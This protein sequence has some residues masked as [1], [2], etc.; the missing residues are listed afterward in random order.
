MSILPMVTMADDS[1]SCGD[2]LIWTYTESTGLLTITGSGEM[3]D[4]DSFP[5]YITSPWFHYSDNINTIVLD[6]GVESTGQFSF[7]SCSKCELIVLPQTIKHIGAY[8]FLGCHCLESIT[9]PDN[10]LSIGDHAF[11]GCLSLASISI[12]QNV[13]S[14]GTM[15]L[16]IA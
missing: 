1:G 15:V 10:V 9:I 3:Y 16:L 11:S 6:E 5:G 8:S 7:A 12:P 4:Y 14:I 2:N 13:T